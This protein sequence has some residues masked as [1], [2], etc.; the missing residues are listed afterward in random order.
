M[1][2]CS[3]GNGLKASGNHESKPLMWVEDIKIRGFQ[4]CSHIK[5]V[6]MQE[7]MF[8][9]WT[10][11]M[12]P[13]VEQFRKQSN[14]CLLWKPCIIFFLSSDVWR[15]KEEEGKKKGESKWKHM[16]VCVP[17]VSLNESRSYF[18]CHSQIPN[19]ISPWQFQ[20]KWPIRH[21]WK[22]QRLG[23]FPPSLPDGLHDHASLP[24]PVTSL[25]CLRHGAALAVL[26]CCWCRG[27]GSGERRLLWHPV[28]AW[29]PLSPSQT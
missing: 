19:P 15:Q 12:E 24:G 27:Y 29:W 2:K 21:C 26:P 18:L 17:T 14:T 9:N 11:A 20:P 6:L 28:P 5:S 16:N 3:H 23:F 8:L 13:D 1:H 4:Q 22:S 7:F 10:F 25:L